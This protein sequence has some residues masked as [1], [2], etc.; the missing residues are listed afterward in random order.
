M[1]AGAGLGLAAMGMG[2]GAGAGAD[3]IGMGAG[4][5]AGAGAPSLEMV[6]GA[7]LPSVAFLLG[8]EAAPFPWAFTQ[9]SLCPRCQSCI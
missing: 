1:G 9:T 8:A 2:A 4:A 5:G 7:V 3:A 6:E